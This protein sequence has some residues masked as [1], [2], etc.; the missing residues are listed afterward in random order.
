M[1]QQIS[2]NIKIKCT[3]SFKKIYAMFILRMNF[4]YN[5][6]IRASLLQKFRGFISTNIKIKNKIIANIYT[7]FKV[8]SKINIKLQ[9]ANSIHALLNMANNNNPF[10]INI[11]MIWSQ[12]PTVGFFRKLF[13]MGYTT[14][15][16]EEYYDIPFWA[17]DNSTLFYLDVQDDYW[18]YWGCNPYNYQ[19]LY[20]LQGF[21]NDNVQ[22]Q[23]GTW[24][25]NR[26]T[27][28]YLA[29]NDNQ[30]NY[31]YI[32]Q[33]NVN[34][35]SQVDQLYKLSIQLQNINTSQNSVLCN[36]F[37]TLNS[38][39]S[40]QT[41]GIYLSSGILYLYVLQQ[42]FTQQP[43]QEDIYNWM[44]Q[45]KLK[46]LVPLQ[47]TQITTVQNPDTISYLNKGSL[48]LIEGKIAYTNNVENQTPDNELIF[49]GYGE[50]QFIV[51][52]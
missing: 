3:T 22:K 5:I 32:Q 30:P 14:E 6:N 44:V 28:I 33:S 31:N 4:Q 42:R 9:L 48:T 52:K 27:Q 15:Q 41:E 25:V 7:I 11:N 36:I 18:V 51:T 35:V 24:R 1:L 43:Q 2:Q 8:S 29:Q 39:P 34:F 46:V 19:A 38:E 10:K 13:S 17:I 47:Q 16:Q 49:F 37:T 45:N 20:S 26:K 12:N 23:G 50:L 40:G 21:G